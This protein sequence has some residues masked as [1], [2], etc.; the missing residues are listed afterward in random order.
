MRIVIGLIAL[1]G[2]AAA[3]AAQTPAPSAPAAPPAAA[4]MKP[5]T[6]PVDC[7][8]AA[9]AKGLNGQ[10]A[11]DSVAL[12]RQELRTACLKEAIDKKIDDKK[13]RRAFIKTCGARPKGGDQGGK[14]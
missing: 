6:K 9:K 11:R 13:E 1:I 10:A 8:A 5:D 3:A 12:C 2:F 7:R 14:S 4:A